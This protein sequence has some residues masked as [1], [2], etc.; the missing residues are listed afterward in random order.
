M[1]EA[2]K[3]AVPEVCHWHGEIESRVNTF[4][5]NLHILKVVVEAVKEGLD[6]CSKQVRSFVLHRLR[7][8]VR[9]V[10]QCFF[11]LQQYTDSF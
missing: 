7:G 1:T 4:A 11:I 5:Q 10:G 8:K 3:S 6:A 2:E 9:H